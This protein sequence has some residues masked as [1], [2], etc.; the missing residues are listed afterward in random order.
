MKANET[1]AVTGAEIRVLGLDQK[2]KG[3]RNTLP[4]TGESREASQSR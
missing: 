1:T 4:G 3:K 2:H